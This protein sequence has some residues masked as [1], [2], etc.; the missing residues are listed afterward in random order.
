M[1]ACAI[2]YRQ[3]VNNYSYIINWVS[4]EHHWFRVSSEV[5]SSAWQLNTRC[6][7]PICRAHGRKCNRTNSST[8]PQKQC[9][10]PV[11][12]SNRQRHSIESVGFR[13]GICKWTII[14]NKSE[15][16]GVARTQVECIRNLNKRKIRKVLHGKNSPNNLVSILEFCREW[17]ALSPSLLVHE[18]IR[19]QILLI[20]K[21]PA[22]S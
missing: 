8:A 4:N 3:Q 10:E 13:S 20:I 2:A 11:A 14:Q 7:R 6:R 19:M 18:R 12:G 16:C 22:A 21:F 17:I 5:I 15:H 1:C 9:I